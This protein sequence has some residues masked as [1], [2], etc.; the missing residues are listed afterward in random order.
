[1]RGFNLSCK[2]LFCYIQ[3]CCRMNFMEEDRKL[4]EEFIEGNEY[5]FEKLLRKYLKPIF[6]FV[7]QLSGDFHV[8][9]DL[10]QE[11]FVKAWKNIKKFDRER[12]FKTWIFTIAK[13]T[14]YDYFKKKKTI[15]LSNFIDEEG[16]NRLDNISDGSILPDEI[17][18]RKDIAIEM[19]KKLEEIPER[20]RIIL[21]MR[22]KNDFSLL[23]IS[24]ILDIPYNTIK[25]GHQ[26]ALQSLRKIL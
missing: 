21:T 15:P 9:E 13:N 16:N 12:S 6:N 3:I 1:M 8:A 10:T 24:E 18:E 22:Y 20:Y 14:T 4:I 2:A 17:L 7:C 23:E 11:T 25:S 5:S 26:R 19:E